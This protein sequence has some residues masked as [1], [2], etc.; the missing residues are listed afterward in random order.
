MKKKWCN[1]SNGNTKKKTNHKTPREYFNTG[2]GS[3]KLITE[4]QIKNAEFVKQTLP[5]K[6]AHYYSSGCDN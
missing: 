2:R 6:M 3:Y 1:K 5:R 4:L